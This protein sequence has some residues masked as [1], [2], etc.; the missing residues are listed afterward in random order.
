MPRLISVTLTEDAVNDRIK[1]VTRRL[2]WRQLRVGDQLTL[3]RKV[4]G[5]KRRD[6]TVEPLVRLAEVEVVDVRRERLDAISLE[7]V[8][9]E[10]FPGMSAAGFVNFFCIHMRCQPETKVTRIEWRYLDRPTA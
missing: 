6:G 1:T 4:M 3:C 8:T 10:G 2:G 5:R 9:L 7:D